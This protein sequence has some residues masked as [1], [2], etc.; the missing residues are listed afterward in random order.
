[1]TN[2]EFF[3]TLAS[4]DAEHLAEIAQL[5]ELGEIVDKIPEMAG[6][7]LTSDMVRAMADHFNETAVNP[8]IRSSVLFG[9]VLTEIAMGAPDPASLATAA[10]HLLVGEHQSISDVLARR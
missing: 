10:L 8:H 9:F 4:L 3:D 5:I 1:M 7:V 2:D 6:S